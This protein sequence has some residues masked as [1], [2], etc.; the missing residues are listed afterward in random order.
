MRQ[1]DAQDPPR[2]PLPRDDVQTVRHAY[3]KGICI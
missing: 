1:N 3:F 2:E